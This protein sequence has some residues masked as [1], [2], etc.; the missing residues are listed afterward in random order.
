MS[1]VENAYSLVDR[2]VQSVDKRSDFV[3]FSKMLEKK[4]NNF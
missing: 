2:V 1:L 4:N 3:F